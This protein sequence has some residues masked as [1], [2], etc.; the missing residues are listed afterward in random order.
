MV[1]PFDL[2]DALDSMVVLIDTREQPTMQS[3]R[4]YE[5]FGVPYERH[6][7]DFGDYS[8]RFRVSDDEWYS[9]ENCVVVERKM[10]FDELCMCFCQ[11][12]GRF[13]REFE[14]IKA[15][16]AKC[17]LLIENAAWEKA[18]NGQY[19]SK[20]RPNALVAS[21]LAFCAR[22]NAVPVFCKAETSGKLIHD[23]LFR[24]GKEALERVLDD[25]V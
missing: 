20:M 15:S 1:N 17:Y 10:N 22:Y 8:A 12:R 5:A 6:K 7:L 3:K 24:E 21:I 9:L 16:G 23:I 4:R 11:Q 25:G 14:R 19:R 2:N 18:Y 13:E